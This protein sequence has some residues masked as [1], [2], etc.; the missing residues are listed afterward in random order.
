MPALADKMGKINPD[1]TPDS[2]I[3]KITLVGLI[4][5]FQ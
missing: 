3:G 5:T 1:A 2:I 4:S